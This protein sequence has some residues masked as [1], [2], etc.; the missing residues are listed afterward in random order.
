MK[1]R[2]DKGRGVVILNKNDYVRKSL[3]ILEGEN[4]LKLDNDPTKGFQTKVQDTLRRMKKA[5]D[6]ETYN[7]LYPSAS[8]PG[9][10]FGLAKY[11]K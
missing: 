10:Y 7:R 2:Q 4:F 5:F 11:T 3:E 9:L 1:L 6:R 8:H